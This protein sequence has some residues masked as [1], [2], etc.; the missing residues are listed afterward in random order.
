[1]FCKAVTPQCVILSVEG[2]KGVFIKAQR[3]G[4]ARRIAQKVVPSLATVTPGLPGALFGIIA[5]LVHSHCHMG[6]MALLLWL[7]WVM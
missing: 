3:D 5:L 1:V 6:P 2:R 4:M 7:E